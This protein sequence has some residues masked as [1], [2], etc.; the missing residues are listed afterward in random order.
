MEIF[1]NHVALASPPMV[2]A[3]DPPSEDAV[4]EDALVDYTVLED[5]DAVMVMILGRDRDCCGVCSS[6]II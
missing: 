6:S 2:V 4:A 3:E 5:T 1:D